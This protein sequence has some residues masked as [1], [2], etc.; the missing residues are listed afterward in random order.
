MLTQDVWTSLAA[1][2]ISPHR[3]RASMEVCCHFPPFHVCVHIV[4]ACVHVQACACMWRPKV[5]VENH[6]QLLFHFIH[7]SKVLQSNSEYIGMVGLASQ[8]ALG[9][10][11]PFC[12]QR[13]QISCHPHLV[14]MWV[15]GSKLHS[16]YWAASILSTKPSPQ[17]A[18]VFY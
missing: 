17:T 10:S 8:S 3:D 9:E 14:F 12:I 16:H 13:L 4:F 6:P 18:F 1:Q 2:E 11:H 7:Q 5:N 15:L